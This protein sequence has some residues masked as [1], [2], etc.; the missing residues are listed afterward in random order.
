M[1]K[2]QLIFIALASATVACSPVAS[3]TT[4]TE[5]SESPVSVDI[6]MLVS[7]AV[8]GI[9]IIGGEL[10]ASGNQYEVTGTLPNGDEIEVDMVQS[11][12]AWTVDEIQRDIAWST[13]PEPVRAVAGAVPDSFEPIRVIESTQA[14]DG[15]IVYE[16]FRATADGSPSRGPAME[17]RWHEGS[18]EVM[19]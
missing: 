19:P 5:A 6:A 2:I 10:N 9:T 1:T 15:S 12:G 16:L 11:N 8:P 7:A 3:Q 14:A 17:V 4:Q 13:V 18:A